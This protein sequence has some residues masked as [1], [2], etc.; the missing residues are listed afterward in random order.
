MKK[1]F[2]FAEVLIVFI[3]VGILIN[4]SIVW[5]FY[6]T[7]KQNIFNELQN[8]YYFISS[9]V[10]EAKRKHCAFTISVGIHSINATV[11]VGN[12]SDKTL[13][14]EYVSLEPVTLS[15][16]TL[17]VFTTYN[18]IKLDN[19]TRSKYNLAMD[20]LAISKFRI[21]EGKLE[22]V[23]GSLKCVCKY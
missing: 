2:S 7:E 19:A 4:L 6:H 17:G 8:I 10:E 3:I 16:N 13:Q 11:N 22:D 5:Y 21:C 20:C 14:L 9:I 18:S 23:S 1:G 15:I 12:C